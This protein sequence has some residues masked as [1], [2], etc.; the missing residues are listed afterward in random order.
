MSKSK[1]TSEPT[2]TK[3]L[4]PV[5]ELRGSVAKMEGQFKLALPKHIPVDRFIRVIQTAAATSP[6]LVQADRTSFFAACMKAAQDG[7]LPDGKESAIV[8]FNTNV[9]GKGN[10][11]WI[12]KAQFMPMVAG[13][14]KKMRNSGELAMITSNVIYKNDDFKYWVDQNGEQLT[15][16]PNLFAD[17]GDRLGVYA[18]AKTKD[19]ANYIEV[20]TAKQ[21]DDVK[22]ASKSKDS[23]PWAG[24]FEDEMW[25]KSAIKRLSKRMP[26]STDLEMTINSDEELF[27]PPAPQPEENDVTPAP[28]PVKSSR[29]VKAMGIQQD[30]VSSDD[31]PPPEDE[32]SEHEPANEHPEDMIIDHDQVP[33]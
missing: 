10:P 8:T 29:L 3:A 22:Q 13:I 30:A 2:Q 23:G 18:M 14:L 7:L 21:V 31:P 24:P 20:L 16:V 12:K 26:M 28:K 32:K 19:G 15:H 17:R 6:D 4:A 11:K 5:D 33:I 27:T 1:P 9:G 25:R